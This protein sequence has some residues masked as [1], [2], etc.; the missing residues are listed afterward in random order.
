[1]SEFGIVSITG[2]E[3]LDRLLKIVADP[4]DGRVPAEARVSMDMLAAQLEGVK[5]KIL[6][7]ALRKALPVVSHLHRVDLRHSQVVSGMVAP[8]QRTLRSWG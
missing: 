3:C 8:G 6:A 7:E 5:A 4:D 2:R 1:L